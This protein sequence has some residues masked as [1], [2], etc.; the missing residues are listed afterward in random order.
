MTEFAASATT[1]DLGEHHHLEP[2][3]NPVPAVSHPIVSPGQSDP[4][5]TKVSQTDGILPI[6]SD[7]H[8]G[9][10]PDIA[11]LLLEI[12]DV[13]SMDTPNQQSVDGAPIQSPPHQCA[14]PQVIH[15]PELQCLSDQVKSYRIF[16]DICSGASRPLS[17]ALI[18]LHADVIISFD[19][20]LD[21][22]MDLLS[23]ASF[24]ALLKL[25]ASGAVA[26]GAASPSCSQ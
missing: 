2:G 24:E 23:D 10:S 25:C 8:F 5:A 14:Q 13:D 21:H 7:S 11:E 12:M 3:P 18:A 19:I 9:I 26:Y 6:T 15:S 1:I 22:R 16:L 17:K 20:R 4:A